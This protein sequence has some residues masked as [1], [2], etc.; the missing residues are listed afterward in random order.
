M[1]DKSE[2]TKLKPDK[3]W[4]PFRIFNIGSAN[5]K[6]LMEYINILELCLGKKANKIFLEMQPGDVQETDA[7][8][9]SLEKYIKYKPKVSIEDGIEKFVLWY[10]SYYGN[11]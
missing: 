3:S 9:S 6:S 11:N 10:R 7:D 2:L 8:I 5:K 4:A 1:R